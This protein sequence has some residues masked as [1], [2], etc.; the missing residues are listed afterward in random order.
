MINL[1]IG[2][3]QP[4]FRT[5]LAKLIAAEDDL[6]IVAQS[7]S[8]AHLRNAIEQLRPRVV[9]LSSDF[10]A[11][12]S[13]LDAILRLGV[14]QGYVTLVLIDRHEEALEFAAMGVQGI[15]PRTAHGDMLIDCIRRIAAGERC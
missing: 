13:D 1:I 14:E 4:I 8:P 6:R 9:L 5:G 3:Q 7:A 15:L 11:A 10:F 12:R 2:T